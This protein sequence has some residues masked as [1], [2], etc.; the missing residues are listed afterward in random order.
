MRILT[1][2][3]KD[4]RLLFRDRRSLVLVFLTPI[5]VIAV[6]ALVFSQKPQGT[7]ISVG[8]CGDDFNISLGLIKPERVLDCD[9]GRRM[10]RGG[11]LAA[12]IVVPP[13]F[14]E[15]V[16][17]GY[18]EGIELYYDNAQSSVATLLLT[19]TRANIQQVS[20]AIGSSFIFIAWSN[21]K[22]LNTKL[23]VASGELD[24]VMEQA[25]MARSRL[26]DVEL[27]LA[28]LQLG[29]VEERLNASLGKIGENN[30]AAREQLARSI[31]A[32]DYLIF[33]LGNIGQA[34]LTSIERL[35]R[36][37][38]LGQNSS[39]C[40]SLNASLN[41]LSQQQNV[42]G[43]TL[44]GSIALLND[45]RQ[46]LAMADEAV[47]QTQNISWED[48]QPVFAGYEQARMSALENLSRAKA[49]LDHML[50]LAQGF[51][52][53]LDKTTKVLDAYVSID[54][55]NIVRP[56]ALTELPVFPTVSNLKVTAPGLLLIV[57]L[58][59][60]LLIS[61]THIVQEKSAGTMVRMLLAP[62]PLGLFLLEKLL[63]L[64][65]ITMIGVAG[66]LI[67]LIG[68]GIT[69]PAGFGFLLVLGVAS[70]VFLCLGFLIGAVS[71]TETTAVLTSLV[72]GLPFLFLSGAFL[73]LALM[74]KAVQTVS[75]KLPL[76]QLIIQ[77]QRVNI[78][79]R[80]A[81]GMTLLGLVALSLVL[82]VITLLILRRQLRR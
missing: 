30:G 6:L 58:F 31:E 21:L 52:A 4:F 38:C 62:I 26:A 61:T 42:T 80:P 66:M 36:E 1:L 7:G 76:T 69:F 55:V 73:P 17:S 41:N 56:I 60:S 23:K 33:S 81:D 63:F 74:G 68:F 27:Q 78:Y 22:E 10:V 77:L 14:Q 40:I 72:I 51:K 28:G 2:L 82:F 53:N 29:S 45:L 32:V 44:A 24:T 43:A 12:L 67:V 49:E 75:L 54:P 37:E 25:Q 8:V 20:D 19:A 46:R 16:M 9:A 57:L 71:K 3:D 35:Y 48:F 59:V 79:G 64:L 13:E 39:F 50:I 15:R 70:L 11:Q 18:G 34:N 47:L 65:I 5:I